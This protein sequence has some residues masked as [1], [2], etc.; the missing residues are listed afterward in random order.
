MGATEIK[1][2]DIFRNDLK[3]SD[4]KARIFAEVVKETVTNEVNHSQTKFKS[5]NREDLLKLEMQLNTKIEQSKSDM[6]KWMFAFWVTIILMLLA[7][8]FLKK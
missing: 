7:N 4:E 6:I 1:L 5:A 3:L 2:Y 8:F